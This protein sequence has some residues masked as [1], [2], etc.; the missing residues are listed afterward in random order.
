MAHEFAIK[1]TIDGNWKPE[2]KD[3]VK[4]LEEVERKLSIKP[5]TNDGIPL[6]DIEKIIKLS[7]KSYSDLI[8]MNKDLERSYTGRLTK[9][10]L[11]YQ[12]T[13]LRDAPKK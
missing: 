6:G 8:K 7:K 13:F 1:L 11:I 10:Q 12:I 5:Y 4:T 3:L 2:L 9:N